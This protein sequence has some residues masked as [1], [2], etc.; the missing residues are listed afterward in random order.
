MLFTTSCCY[1][2]DILQCGTLGD[3]IDLTKKKSK[4]CFRFQVCDS[5]Y[6]LKFNIIILNLHDLQLDQI[7]CNNSLTNNELS[8]VYSW[9][10]VS[11]GQ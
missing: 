10:S 4:F 2:Y 1:V 3:G 5:N 9:F 11:G 7:Y 8:V 6:I